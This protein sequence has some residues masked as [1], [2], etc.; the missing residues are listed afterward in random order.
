MDLPDIGCRPFGIEL[1]FIHCRYF[2]SS[3]ALIWQKLLLSMNND[4]F[5]ATVLG[6]RPTVPS[7]PT[8]V[9]AIVGVSDSGQ[10]SVLPMLSVTS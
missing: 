4:Y 10:R 8:T 2:L 9:F 3:I 1:F 5:L 7:G 6:C